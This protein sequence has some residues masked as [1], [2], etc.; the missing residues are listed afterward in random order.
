MK[1]FLRLR[2]TDNKNR[3][4]SILK[5]VGLSLLGLVLLAVIFGSQEDNREGEQTS[6]APD[7][8]VGDPIAP[9]ESDSGSLIGEGETQPPSESSSDLPIGADSPPPIQGGQP[10]SVSQPESETATVDNQPDPNDDATPV[11]LLYM[12][13]RVIDGDT[14]E[15][16]IDGQPQSLRVIGVDTPETVDPRRS[17]ECLGV[18]AKARANEILAGQS[19]YL[20]LDPSQD[21]RDR[22]GRLL[23]H[24]ILAD[25]RNYGLEIIGQGYGHEYTYNQPH[26]YQAEFRKA[27]AEARE[28]GRGLWA[29]GVCVEESSQNGSMADDGSMS[30]RDTSDPEDT[31]LAPG[32]DGCHPAYDPCLE[33]V[34]DLN[35]GDIRQ[36][37]TVKQIG[38]D[39]YGLDRDDDGVGC[40]SYN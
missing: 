17:V 30:N 11:N 40:E 39:P 35:C 36:A 9:P 31:D 28:A 7:S 32:G 21:D 12:V 14:V 26:A 1:D 6:R 33:I 27:E 10:P 37:V 20:Q 34:G 5:L 29:P 2:F 38:V 8:S 18:E 3:L 15:I 4:V 25:G 19:I 22:Y 23:R 16:L 13:N 24:I